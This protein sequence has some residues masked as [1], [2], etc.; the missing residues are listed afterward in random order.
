M[1]WLNMPLQF[2]NDLHLL[3]GRNLCLAADARPSEVGQPREEEESETD[4][5][6]E[7]GE[8]EERA[9]TIPEAK[10]QK[11]ILLYLECKGFRKAVYLFLFGQ[12]ICRC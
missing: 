2:P 11:V 1:K 10:R 9:N 7:E 12:F 8:Y 4:Y 3:Y 6:E 5:R